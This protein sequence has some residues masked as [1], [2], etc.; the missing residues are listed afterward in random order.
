MKKQTLKFD[1]LVTMAIFS[2]QV[3]SG[4]LM[5]TTNCTLTGKFTE[6]DIDLALNKYNA[7][8]IET[9]EKVFTYQ[10]F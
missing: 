10:S 3:A 9:T 4:Y 6:D 2:K 7:S 8:V 1:C 5:N